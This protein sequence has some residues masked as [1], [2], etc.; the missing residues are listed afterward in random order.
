MKLTKKLEAE[1]LKAYNGYWDSYLN[2]DMKTMAS[3]L[4]DDIKVIGST[5]TEVFY[6]KKTAMKFYSATAGQI[7]GTA[8]L[9]NRN[10][11]IELIDGLV[12]ITEKL[13][14]YALMEGKWTFY[15]KGRLSSLLWKKE[16]GWKLIQQHGSMPDTRAEEGEQLS[17]K[18]I[19][20]ENRKLREAVKRRTIEL[21]NKNRELEIETALEK[22]RAIALSM[23]QPAD[24]LDVCKTI[25][26][27]LQSLDVKDIRNVQTAI[28]Y[29]SLGT[30]MNYEYY[31]RHH[32][33][34]I[35]ETI[36]TDHKIAK[37]FAA[38]MLKGKGEVSVT[39][40]KGEKVKDW[41]AYQKGTNVF[42]DKYLEK[43][44]SLHYYW[45]SLGPVALGISTYSP[46][47]KE[48][49]NLFNRFLNVFE[50]AYTRYLDI[51]QAIAQAREAK[52]QASLEKVRA[53]AL[54][55]RKP[56][57][58]PGIC[59]ALFG[60]LRT[61]GFA[62]IRN[63]MINIHDDEK[64][65]F[66]NYDYSDEIGK[67]IN[68]LTYNIHPLIEKQIKQVRSTNGFSETSFAGKDL[69]DWKAFRKK[70]GEKDDPR[71]KNIDALH[72]YFYSIGTGSIGIST[73][74][75]IGDEKLNVL[76]R[77]RNVFDFAYRR[78]MDV[79]QAEAQ[80]KEAQIEL[81][82]ERVR[83]RTMAMQ[84]SDELAEVVGLL[85]KQFEE[86]DFGLYQILVSILDS[87][88]NV[89]EWWSR[90]FSEV[91]LPQRNLIPIID[92][93]FSNAQREKWE[94][95]IPYYAHV[96]E[97]DMKKSWE[98]YLFTQTDLKNFPQEVK[99]RMRSLKQVYL[100]DAFMK[101][102]VLQA[103][104][105]APLP[106][107]KAAILKRFAKVL[108]LAYTRM[109]D[110][111][112]AEA[113]A[114]EAQIELA[115]ERVRAR[116]MAMQHTE[117]LREAANLLFQQVQSL[118]IPIWSC[119][120]NI[121]EKGEKFCTGWMS[122]NGVIQ[123]SFRIPLTIGHTFEHMNES[124]L[125]GEPFYVEEMSGE[126]LAEHYR[127][128]FSLP[129]F[130]TIADEQLNDGFVLPTFQINHVFN[131]RH[132]NL[133]FLSGQPIPQAWE[134]FKR[135]TAVFEQTYTRFLD[136]QKAEA[137]T[138][139]AQ[140][141]VAVERVRAKALAMHKSEDLHSVVVA[142]KKELM[143]LQIP[144][145]T[146]ATI[147]LEQND[148]SIRVLDLSDTAEQD[149]DKP[150]LQLDKVFQL[151][152]TDPKLWIR[153]MWNRNENYFVLEANEDDFVRVVKWIKTVDPD[154]AE[155]AERIIRE[156]SIKKAWLPTVK[157]EKGVMNIDLLAPPT[158]EI[159]NILLKMGAG[160]DLAYKRFLDLQKAEEQ[161]R[162]AKIETALER[163]RS[164]SMGMQKSEEL[165]EVIQ[166]VYEQFV[167]L[168]IHVE[169][170]GFIMDYKERNDMHIWLADKHAV[171]FQVTIPYFDSAHWNS[172]NDA[173]EKGLDF[174]T[175]NLSFEEKNKFYQDLFKLIPGVPEETLQYYFS[176]PG[177]AISTVLLDNV[178]L[179]IENFS[180]IP[181]IDEENNTLM[182]FGKVFQQ[183]YTRFLD[184]K[185][186]EAQAREG[187]IELALERVRA[188]TMAM[189]HS[190]EL[191]DT[192][193][194]LFQQL[195]ELGEPA[196]QCTI[197]IINE[198][199]GVVE[200]SATLHG[201]KMQQTFRHKIDEPFVMNK[202]FRGWKDQQRTLVLELK[203]QELQ[204]YNQ[205]RNELVGKETFPVKLL[206]GDSWIIHIA[207][208][209]K[210]ML[211]LSTNEPR[212]AVSLQLLERFAI[213][214]EQTYTRFLDLQKAEAQ[215]REAQIENA[216]EKV[217]SRTMAMQKSEELPEA[218]NV[219]FLQVQALGIP[220]WSCG[221]NILAADKKSSTCIMSS[222][223]EIQ[224]PFVLPL[225]EHWSLLPW[226]EAIQ[227]NLDFFV[228]GQGG[229]DL[230][231]HYKYLATVP[232]LEKVFQQFDDA[233]ISLPANQIN[234][235]VRFTNGFLLF[236]TY[237]S[238]PH[239]HEIF[240][241]FGKV[242]QQ[243]Y[244]RFLDLQKAEAQAREGQIELAMERV[245]SRTM[246][247]HKSEE[248][249]DVAS[250]LFEELQKLGF[251]FGASSILIMD[252]ESGDAEYWMAGF[253]KEKFPE[254][255]QI[256][257][258]QHPYH[259]AMLTAWKTG[260]KSFIY[261]LEGAEKKA[262]DEVLFTQTGYKYIPEEEQKLMRGI[263]SVTF[264]IA[265]MKHGALHWGP[266]PLNEEQTKI[267]ERFAKVF[268]QAYIRFLDLQKA[269]AQAR[270][271]QIEAA[272]EKVRS[273]SLAMHHST[274]LEQVA[275]SLFDRLAELGLSFD[276]AFIFI[277]D[278][279]KRNISLWI[280]TNHL[281]APVKIDLPYDKAVEN[282]TILKDLWNAIENGEHII[283]RSYSGE[284]KNE[285]FRYVAKYNESKIP[286]S[287]RQFQIEK[288]SWTAH[289]VAE[290]NSMIGFDSWSGHPTKE[291]DFKILIRFAK[292]FEQ[293]YTRFADL[294]KAEAQAREAK[295]EL[296]LERVRA[297]AMA[298]Q[299]SD[300][301]AGAV[302]VIFEE[303]DKLNIGI[304]RCGIGILNKE[305]R[306]VNVWTTSKSDENTAVQISGDESMDSHPLLQGAF[307]AWLKQEEYSY[308][309]HGKDL[310]DYYKA[311]AAANFKLPDSQSLT[312]A[313][314][315]L[316][317]YYFLATFQAG[318]LFA[319]RQTAFTEEAKKVLKRFA[320][321]FNLTYKRFIDL[322]KAEAQTREAKIEAALEK[323]RSR[324]MGMQQS[325]ELGDVA[326]V[327]FKE[328]NQLV[329]NL[330]TCGFVLCEKDRE[331]DEWWLST[332][333]G[334]IPAFY[335]PN[336]GDPTHANIYDAW[337]KEETYH[338]EQLEGEALQEHYDWLMNIPVSK[339]I[340]DEM[341]AAGNPLPTWQKLHCAYFSYGYLV[342]I[343][344][345][346]CPEEQIFKRFAQVFDQTYTRFLDLQKA[347]GQAREAQIELALERVRSRAMAMQNSNEL[348]ELV[349]TLF[350]ELTKLDFALNWCIINL[351]DVGTLSNTVWA[352]NPDIN[353]P[354]DSYHMKF[355]D[356]P[357][358][359]AMMKGYQERKTKFIYVIEG[360]E[361][362]IYDEY[363]F[364]ETAFSKVP[365]EAQAASRAMEKYVCSFTF[366]NFGGLQTVGSEPLL[367]ANLDIL[368]RFGK[369]FD[370]TYTRFN[371]L[372][373]AEQLARQAQIDL[374][375][376]IAAKKKTDDAL[377][378][379]KATQT[380][381]IQSEKMASLGELTAGIAHEIQNPLN[382]VN[383]FSEVS[384]ELIDEMNAEI[385]KGDM[386]EAKAIANDIKQN[387]EKI[388]HHGKRADAIVK[389]M[390]Q[391]S[392]SSSAT[393]E[394]TDI[395]KLADEYLRL[396][397]HGLRAKDKSF[398]A[399]MKTDFD[400]SIGNINIIPQ[401]IGRVILNLITNAFYVVNEKKSQGL[402]GYEPTVS[403]STK[404]DADKIF[405]SV[406][407]NGNGIPQKVLDKIFQ[408]FFTTKPTGQGTG[409]G[410][411]LSYDI[412]KAHGGELKV[413]TKE[414]EGSVFIIE[415]NETV[416]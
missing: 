388:N 180:G 224:V 11:K 125:K 212:P 94:S 377:T 240:K 19:S 198:S 144:D 59:E 73:F 313:N 340:F 248:V 27:Q 71:I 164:R 290:K 219:L 96:L 179:Y 123:P 139:E 110:L 118:G 371:D 47:P 363:L 405:V 53:Q 344:Q 55:M 227:N 92:H 115:L 161:A 376:L 345:V 24:M 58:L 141:E 332:G 2:G 127:N 366:S 76:K 218:A 193:L 221:Y 271:A 317:Q 176:C 210:G 260:G 85:Y 402:E 48:E 30:Y 151:E 253:S 228:Y 205:Y 233:G 367:E 249:M 93:P 112:N 406:K 182:R 196:E 355:E 25:S 105:P 223:G 299:K 117:E 201:N 215:A 394:P 173:K 77:F 306:S 341:K 128:M 409:L 143:K 14:F 113:Q 148:G 107:D 33:T 395:N 95:G 189:Q 300:D 327:L 292:V 270:E 392:R 83:A 216:L 267:L 381:L 374:E 235:L 65:S 90:G 295:I 401:D 10:I 304:L 312:T 21:E 398:N 318:G 104:G 259:D 256:K 272:L 276:G 187:Q 111:L 119:G 325:H 288:E 170:T 353:K 130:K 134:T 245:R 166:V 67:T 220:A 3:F 31:A 49:L 349:D 156:K 382:F 326:T 147:Y 79:A 328:L 100:S 359:D 286:E 114:K 135:F 162:E 8:Q 87:K 158:P 230:I 211:A 50:L 188:R 370:L 109:T 257:Y 171:P 45:H 410:L 277:F 368:S 5:E 396:A 37:A 192:S 81:A 311:Q 207:Y 43:A 414:G 131:F 298:M 294:Q 384:N 403:V 89:I 234:H 153:R 285:Y 411:S 375:N 284:V 362:K 160:F 17:V 1:V 231:E 278:K 247:M 172:F 354:P 296:G 373:Q 262:Y 337:K 140:I 108:D 35:T 244:T 246:A 351:I 200:I 68:Q 149:D 29:V 177:L 356:Y 22:V 69:K 26:L 133:I 320:G 314:E 23:K 383:N 13:D 378:E 150:Q 297:R 124:R 208:F 84:Q 238:V 343:T 57:D 289:L 342:M 54:G 348:S 142:L 209:S 40:I 412:V 51:E 102:G 174:F 280:A 264:S 97:G 391:H 178:G 380:Q 155:M 281:S 152:A 184:L 387:L 261:T 36:Y 101:Y 364:N 42:I 199:E 413:E 408:P 56:D 393:K 34:F 338:T 274:E 167:H 75:S 61:L 146:A 38:K 132:G 379:L 385:E 323:V 163:V 64:R 226:Y 91:D 336:T 41:I 241:R 307:D 217:R 202:I 204:K 7:A 82:L 279:E 28:F 229:E 169:H 206:P 254:S 181:Y 369:V 252:K 20:K 352:A 291:E 222:E 275:G 165:K 255:Y 106:D 310:T 120:Y 129:D 122:T 350:K 194:I 293:A 86:L 103:A 145:I 98:E 186:A 191:Q 329:E 321:V 346:P 269:E 282:N 404:K 80:A 197:G 407:D 185:K 357:F 333:D 32:K 137:Q 157:L 287:V 44:S 301:L 154:G 74:S 72:Y 232:G 251:A 168:N 386:V 308:I 315:E 334:F 243:T 303:L 389:G 88:N 365:E 324:T 399:T 242:F 121:W 16:D 195:K 237:E 239:A 331:E 358:H 46:L 60:E 236:I 302:A 309:L 66:I 347:E 203:E 330:W 283:S 265:Y 39:H 268:E 335:L 273:S 397:Y 126:E 12:L 116:T 78:Y 390:L 225:T 361:K 319:F 416:K 136:L 99:D 214:F 159:E 6:N 63:A 258:F 339:N 250:T 70:I 4:D 263:E 62:E 138:R 9:R 316:Y 360:D 183:T 266:S 213:V 18:K 190:E 15:A 52:I 175:N 400:E 305:N 372:R 415:L 322:Q